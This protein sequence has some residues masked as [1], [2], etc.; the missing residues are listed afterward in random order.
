[1]SSL[2]LLLMWQVTDPTVD[3]LLQNCVRIQSLTLNSC[4]GVT[5]LTLQSLSKYTPYIRYTDTNTHLCLTYAAILVLFSLGYQWSSTHAG[6]VMGM[7]VMT[8]V[9]L[10]LTVCVSDPSM[11]AV[12]RRWQMQ[13]FGLWLWGVEDLS[14][15]ISAPLE[16]E[17]EGPT[18]LNVSLHLL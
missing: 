17:T 6:A 14:S 7:I 11:W 15:W 9:L 10:T 3:T 4:P 1:M 5:D 8:N 12:V 13:E 2:C 16:P 18:P